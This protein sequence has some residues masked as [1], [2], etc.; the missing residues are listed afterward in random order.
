LGS[1]NNVTPPPEIS[2]VALPTYVTV[3]SIGI[4]YPPWHL[5]CPAIVRKMPTNHNVFTYKH[6]RS[7]T[8]AMWVKK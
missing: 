1:V 3:I 8:M 4:G 7:P 2:V 5:S 6:A